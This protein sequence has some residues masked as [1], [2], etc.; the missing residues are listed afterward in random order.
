MTT[1]S[2]L[3]S[4]NVPIL[5]PWYTVCGL[6]P[7]TSSLSHYCDPSSILSCIFLQS[8]SHS[9]QSNVCSDNSVVTFAGNIL[10]CV[11][12]TINGVGLVNGFI[13]HLYT[14]FISTSNC[15]TTTDLHNSQ[16]IIAPAPP[17]FSLLCLHQPFPGNGF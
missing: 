5:R 6:T 12:V 8:F 13:D 1:F 17:F 10:S 3:V 16:I 15:S 7:S 2:V 4:V 9:V 11:G 14:H